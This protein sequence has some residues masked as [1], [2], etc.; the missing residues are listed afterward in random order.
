MSVISHS[1]LQESLSEQALKTATY[2]LN[3]IS[4]KV[5]IKIPYELQTGKKPSQKHL[6]IWGRPI[7]RSNVCKFYDPTNMSILKMKNARFFEDME[8]VKGDKV[9]N[10]IFNKKYI[11][12]SY[13]AIDND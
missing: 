6:H 10:F 2:I 3:R 11:T 1:I 12:V 8:F 9:R 5:I 4:S 13:V 7:E